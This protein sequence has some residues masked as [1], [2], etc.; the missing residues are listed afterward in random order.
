MKLAN[1]AFGNEVNIQSFIS[2]KDSP[3]NEDLNSISLGDV[4]QSLGDQKLVWT[5]TEEGI[6]R[7]KDEHLKR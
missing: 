6:R 5:F 7:R 1:E 2:N 3:S 4:S